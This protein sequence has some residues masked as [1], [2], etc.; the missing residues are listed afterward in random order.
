MRNEE[1]QEL[2]SLSL[3]LHFLKTQLVPGLDLCT[4]KSWVNRRKDLK[5]LSSLHGSKLRVCRKNVDPDVVG[6]YDDASRIITIVSSYGDKRELTTKDIL[7]SFSHE[8]SH[9][10]QYHLLFEVPYHIR[11]K[12]FGKFRNALKQEQVAESLAYYVSTNYFP[13]LSVQ[14]GISRE[15]FKTYFCAE[16]IV[17]VAK[18]YGFDPC[19]E[20]VLKEIIEVDPKYKG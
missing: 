13:T 18:R 5:E 16:D 14:N 1:Y 12:F 2:L 9:A 4:S 15:D 11:T 10:I 19:E 20:S 8:L 7:Y 3:D 6:L 17:Y